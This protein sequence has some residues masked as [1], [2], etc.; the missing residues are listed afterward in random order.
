M[1]GL[2]NARRVLDRRLVQWRRLEPTPP[3]RGWIR[4]IRQ[5]LGMSAT[6]LADRMG[7][8]QSRITAIEHGEVAGTI[9]LDTLRRAAN[10]LDCDLYYALVPRTPLNDAVHDQ[11]RRK[12]VV[13][14]E[15]VAHHM[16]LED[17]NVSERD[18]D[19]AVASLAEELID[20]RGLWT[21]PS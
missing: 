3:H 14:L 7:V 6:E 8:V 21:D 9:K 11:A 1:Q 12:A 13:V 5:A 19:D 18:R 20:T 2:P 17:Q 4:A 10:A 16:R 15:G